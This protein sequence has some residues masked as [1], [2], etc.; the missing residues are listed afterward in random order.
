MSYLTP[1][2]MTTQKHRCIP[3]S[4]IFYLKK[5]KILK[6]FSALRLFPKKIFLIAQQYK[7]LTHSQTKDLKQ[8]FL[9]AVP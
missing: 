2:K 8:C 9:T 4:C 1:K 5:K 3:Y 7:T 6:R